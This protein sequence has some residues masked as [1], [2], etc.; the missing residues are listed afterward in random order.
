MLIMKNLKFNS[1]LLLFSVT[2]LAFL[3]TGCQKDDSV[4]PEKAAIE[5]PSGLETVLSPQEITDYINLLTEVDELT[6]EGFKMIPLQIEL[7][8]DAS[9]YYDGPESGDPFAI[10]ISGTG[11]DETLGLIVYQERL[12]MQS[13]AGVA[14]GEGSIVLDMSVAQ[15]CIPSDPTLFFSTTPTEKWNLFPKGNYQVSAPV[16]VKGGLKEFEGAYGEASRVITFVEG[17]F[18]KGVGYFLG[19]V[20]I[21]EDL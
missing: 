18:D 9:F 7:D 6:P 20:Y 1:L 10:T 12:D 13:K 2:I 5:I 19:F 14:P 16:L 8:V 17:Q 4:V 3:S 15:R 21:P 11:F